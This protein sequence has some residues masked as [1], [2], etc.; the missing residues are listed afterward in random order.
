MAGGRGRHRGSPWM[1]VA[2]AAPA[3]GLLALFLLLPVVVAGSYSTTEAS[4]Y[5]DKRPVGLD[6]YRAVLSDQAFWSALTR[7]VVLAALVA[8]LTLTAGFTLAYL[9]YVGVRGWRFLQAGLL[10]PYIVPVVVT[11]L[12]WKAMLEPENGVVNTVLRKSGLGAL[13]NPWLTGEQTS[14]PTV[15]VIQSWVLVPF[16]M[17]ILFGAMLGLPKEMLEAAELDGA[18]HVA[19]MLRIVLPA[20]RPTVLL[21]TFVVV[22]Q[23]FRSFDLVWLLTQGGPLSSTTIG[24]LYVYLLGF[25]DNEYGYANAVGVV[26][27][28]MAALLVLTPLT[29]ARLRARRRAAA[30]EP[31]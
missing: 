17:L 30:G 10:V 24:T 2:F 13:A 12:M 15:A 3:T 28:A 11:A 16:A 8:L 20:V 27:G 25:V 4:G 23:M 1:G 14:L 31:A 26:L 9:L 22:V 5:G 6:N 18:G 21:V 19:R 29:V 7:N